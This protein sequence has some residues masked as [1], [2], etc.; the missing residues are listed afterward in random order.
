MREEQENETVY[1]R[2]RAKEVEGRI[3]AK[4]HSEKGLVAVIS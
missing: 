4:L 2:R 3:L 1:K